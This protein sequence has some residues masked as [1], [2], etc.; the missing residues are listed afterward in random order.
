MIAESIKVFTQL[1][2]KHQLPFEVVTDTPD[3]AILQI[4]HSSPLLIKVISLGTFLQIY[5]FDE[6]SDP[7]IQLDRITCTS[8][9]LTIEFLETR[10]LKISREPSRILSSKL[11]RH[12]LPFLDS[13]S[14]GKLDCLS[15]Q[16]NEL[17]K[18][19]SFWRDAY[20]S[21][22]TNFTGKITRL[23]HKRA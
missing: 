16:F 17:L 21:R 18:D 23:R 9:F 5:V 20:H 11:I 7:P 4:S 13:K 15:K 6:S 2:E 3:I 19:Q 14:V 8:K 12:L 1:S 22:T 10:L